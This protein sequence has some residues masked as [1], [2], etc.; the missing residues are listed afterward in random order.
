MTP[1][2]AEVV[3]RALG[4]YLGLALGDALGATVEFMRPREIEH[5][6]GVH[7]DIVGGGWL[8]LPRGAVTDDTTLSL[9]LGQ[10]MVSCQ[11]WNLTAVADSFSA[12]LRAKPVDCGNTCRRGI[13]RY[14]TSGTL[15]A[16]PSEADGGNGALMR[17]LPVVLA[18]LKDEQALARWTI[19]QCHITHHHRLS[20][21]ATLAISQMAR[22][23]VLGEPASRCGALAQTLVDAHP[24][25][26]FDPYPGR[27]SGYVVDTVQTVLHYFF[28]HEDF[29][30]CL[31]ATVNQG[32]DADTTGAVAGMLAGARC[33]AHKLPARWLRVLDHSIEAQIRTQ[34]T[35]LLAL[36]ARY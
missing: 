23:L 30:R 18:S 12:W 28:A 19:A 13:A 21:A 7:R 29:E 35:A 22:C 6:W 4:A 17:N 31:I 10:A 5:Q 9:A 3:D 8:K 34:T 24:V 36:A 20:D 16:M 25:F 2:P 32:E 11:G 15:A 1:W 14:I 33:G 27:A 26:R